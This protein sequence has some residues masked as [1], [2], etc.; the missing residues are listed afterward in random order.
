MVKIN[1][2]KCIKYI[3][4][5]RFLCSLEIAT[6][7][8]NVHS[9][10]FAIH[11]KKVLTLMILMMVMINNDKDNV[12]NNRNNADDHDNDGQWKYS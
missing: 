12:N 11:K 9:C 3:T 2:T 8:T 4:A 5:Q 7:P 10:H 6:V 1:L